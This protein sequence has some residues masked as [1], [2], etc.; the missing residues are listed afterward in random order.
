MTVAQALIA[1]AVAA[2][3]LTLA[4][5]L[6]TALVLRA[7]AVE[8]PKRAALAAIGIGAGCLAWGAVA[9]L[10][11]TALLQ[12]SALAFTALKWAGAAYLVWLGLNMLLRPR[13]RFEVTAA[14]PS[15]Q[16]DA[17]WLRRGLLTNLLNP[18]VGVFYVS[19][20]PQFLPRGVAPAPF[21]FL[22]AGL[23]VVMGLIWF[24]CLIAA[25]QPIATALKRPAV[26]RWLDR[27]TGAVFLGFGVKLAL[28]RR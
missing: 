20:L 19:F 18:K 10:G 17:A 7:A 11:L 3:L 2:G 23:H 16:G 28:E 15:G 13:V 6:D 4:P 1:F 25:T 14:A 8:G 26:V 27:A 5:G 9:A 24:A 12:A 21:I 22:L